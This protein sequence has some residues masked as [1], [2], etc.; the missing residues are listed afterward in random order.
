[1]Q[2]GLSSA[3]Q[4]LLQAA[5]ESTWLVLATLKEEGNA[6]VCSG[7]YNVS[8]LQ[9]GM[10]SDYVRAAVAREHGPVLRLAATDT[11][12]KRQRMIEEE[13]PKECTS[14]RVAFSERR[15]L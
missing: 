4:W 3:V 9:E 10:L 2:S 1:M 8:A 12:L 7:H 6:F 11:P 5:G 15:Q 14:S 13:M